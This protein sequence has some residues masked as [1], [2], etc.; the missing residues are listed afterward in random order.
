MTIWNAVGSYEVTRNRSKSSS[1]AIVAPLALAAA[2]PGAFVI[3]LLPAQPIMPVL[4]LASLSSAAVVALLAWGLG[5]ER[6]TR[7][8]N[9]WDTAGAYAFIG[10]GAGMLSKSKEILQLVET[11]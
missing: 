11:L 5:A 7:Y 10:F 2:I 8:F 9:L 1:R 4:C 6:Q 3:W